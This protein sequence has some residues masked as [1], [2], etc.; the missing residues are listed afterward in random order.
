MTILAKIIVDYNATV[1]PTGGV[2]NLNHHISPANTNI[3]K[4]NRLFKQQLF[5]FKP[6]LLILIKLQLVMIV[7]LLLEQGKD[8]IL[9]SIKLKVD[10]EKPLM[11]SNN[12]ATL[13]ASASVKKK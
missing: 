4:P 5:Q 9:H 12:N 7:V 13:K 11:M 10:L 1:N 8:K 2:A 6:L 3:Q